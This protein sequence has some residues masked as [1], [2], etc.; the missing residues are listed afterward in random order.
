MGPQGPW[1]FQGDCFSPQIPLIALSTTA[2]I[3]QS[4]QGSASLYCHLFCQRPCCV[5]K[6]WFL[7][8]AS[9]NHSTWPQAFMALLGGGVGGHAYAYACAWRAGLGV[10]ARELAPTCFRS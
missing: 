6:A 1:G 7:M 9:G 5:G 8:V 10:T 2:L 3:P 4:L